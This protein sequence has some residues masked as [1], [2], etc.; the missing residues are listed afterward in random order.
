MWSSRNIDGSGWTADTQDQKMDVIIEV[1]KFLQ[2]ENRKKVVKELQR[3][4]NVL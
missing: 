4:D 1:F 3:L 2:P